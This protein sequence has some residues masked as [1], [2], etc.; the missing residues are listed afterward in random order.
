MHR[1][2]KERKD[3]KDAEFIG[4]SRESTIIIKVPLTRYQPDTEST[5]ILYKHADIS[6]NNQGIEDHMTEI[7]HDC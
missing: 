2:T 6:N 3:D 1:L 4:L 7:F 5:T